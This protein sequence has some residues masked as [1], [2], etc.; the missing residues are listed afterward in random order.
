M[1]FF[2]G[3][4]SPINSGDKIA[5]RSAFTRGPYSEMWLKCTKGSCV[6]SK[7]RSSDIPD[8]RESPSCPMIFT[9]WAKDRGVINSGDTVSLSPIKYGP[10]FLLSCDDS[11]RTK[12]CVKS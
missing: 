1:F 7:C 8:R 12:C 5:L 3:H 6:L 2:Q 10:G 11:K 9:I 4:N